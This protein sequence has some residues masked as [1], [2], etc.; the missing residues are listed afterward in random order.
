VLLACLAT[1]RSLAQ[2]TSTLLPDANV[3]A[4]GNGR[5]RLL[6]SFTRWDNLLGDGG[7]RNIGSLF[8][9]DTFGVAQLPRLAP[10]EADI[11]AISGLPNFRLS[12]GNVRSIAD[13][14][15][16]TAPLIAEYGLTSRL[17]LGIA[18]PFV[19]TRTTLYTQLNALG[20]SLDSGRTRPRGVGANVGLNPALLPGSN[21]VNVN[22]SLV[23]SLRSAQQ[24]LQTRLNECIATPSGAGCAPILA[25]QSA[26]QALLQN[27]AALATSVETLYGTNRT[28]NPGRLFVPL[29]SSVAQNEIR[30]RINGVALQYK[31]FLGSEVIQ[32]NATGAAGP[33]ANLQLQGL[34]ASVG[35]DTARSTNRTSL[36]DI[37][38]GV[39]YQLLNSYTTVTDTMSGSL[40][41]RVA[42]NGTFRIGTGQP[43]NRNRM[44]D[45]GTGYGQNGV[46]AGAAIDLAFG[47]TLSTTV[48]GLYTAQL[49]SIDINRVPNAGGSIYPLAAAFS[50]TYSA[51]DVAQLVV[52]PRIR[53]AGFLALTGH[54]SL[55]RV[56]ADEYALGALT[57]TSI[58]PDPLD[59]QPTAPFGLAAQTAQQVGMGF[60]YATNIGRGRGPGAIPVEVLYTH[61]ET[62]SGSG[63]PV[64]KTTRDQIELRVY[65]R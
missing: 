45:V 22:N 60:T 19:Q 36:G 21:A 33:G 54:Y 40:R 13:S 39:T 52:T 55:L 38:V 16:A 28:T 62:I 20:V 48:L 44:F 23:Q 17:T 64:P 65:W 15:V 30:A 58:A 14:R 26:V 46:E 29:D 49:G 4:R 34:L 25:Q 37:S 41:Y 1:H 10:I 24:T 6:T 35:R 3:L 57:D 11:R 50:G 61:Y 18:I 43:A 47:Q 9:T 5:I 56:G 42:L 63:G 27:S 32:G 8:A 31:S 59:V 51:G 7:T 2:P 53:L 12:A